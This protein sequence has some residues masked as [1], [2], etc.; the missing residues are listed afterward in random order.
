MT[1]KAILTPCLVMAMALAA[2]AAQD[3]SPGAADDTPAAAGPGA[4][5]TLAPGLELSTPCAAVAPSAATAAAMAAA[6]GSRVEVEAERTEYS[7][8]YVEPSGSHTIVTAVAPQ[9]ARRLDGTWGPI[10]TTLVQIGDAIVP[11][12]SA[13]HLRFSTGGAG[14]FVTLVHDGHSFSLSWPAPLPAPTLAGDTATYANV[15]PDVDLVVRATDAGFSHL[16]VVKTA[17]AAAHPAVRRARYR[18]G[19]D[20]TLRSTPDGG[21][22]AEAGGVRVASAGPPMMWGNARPGSAHAM[23][24]SRAGTGAGRTARVQGAISSGQLILTPDAAMLADPG[25]GFPLVIDP[26]FTTGENQWAYASADN[27]NAPTTD[28][29][30]AAGDPSPAAAELRVGNDP[31]SSH[32][33]RSFMRFPISTVAGR[34]ILTAQISG[35]V[36]HTWKCGSNRPTYFYRTAGISTTPRQTWPGPALQLLLGNDNVHANEDSC[37]EA[38]MPFEVSTSTLINDLQASANAS[39]GSYFIGIS[40]GENTSGLNETDQ[41]RWM[42]YFLADFKLQITY[43]TKPNKPD[44]LTVDGKPCVSGA[45]RPFVK[46]TTPTLRAHVVDPDGDTM[47]VSFTW[48]KWNGTSFVDEPGGGKQSNVPSGGT[49]LFN[50]TGNVDGGIYTFR[51]QSDDSPSHSPHLVSDV[52]NLPGNCEWQVDISPPAVPTVV[53]DVYLEGPAGCPGG[54]CGSV[55]QTGHFTFSSSSDTQ[56][57][58]W[59][60]SDPP[61]TPLTPSA[62]G[63]SVSID[64]TPTSSG[65]RTLFVRAIDRAGNVADKSYQFIVAAESTALAR[66]RLDDT[67]GS[68][69]TGNGFAATLSGGPVLGAGRIVPGLDGQSRSAL[70]FDGIDDVATTAGPVLADTSKSFSVAAW[71][72]L[73]DNTAGHHILEQTGPT[74]SALLLEYAHIANAWKITAPSADG[75]AFPGAASTSVPRLNTWTHVVGTYDSAAHTMKIYVNGVPETTA[76]GITTWQATGPLRIGSGW[77]GSLAEVQVWNRVLSDTEVFD[78]SDPMKVGEVAV[79]HMEEVGPGPAF[80][81]SALAHDLT[82]FNGASIPPTGAGQT[83]TGLQLDGIDDYAAPDGQVLHTDQSFTVSLWVRPNATATQQ[84]FISQESLSPGT[85]GGFALKFGPD[86]GGQWKFRIYASATDSADADATF[87]TAPATNVTTAF[88]HLVGVFDA[89]KL[90]IRLYVDGALKMTTAMN[91]QWHA[92]DAAGRLVLGRHQPTSTL[93]PTSGDLDEVRVYQGVVTDVTRIP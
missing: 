81:S 75:T 63:G 74:G 48:A 23:A 83:G 8:V 60:W 30:I 73:S 72:K 13:A 1:M 38:N 18:V 21:L 90:E 37:G 22:V 76:T 93:E 9:R 39:A 36:D 10:D 7:E 19:G 2:C 4:G 66:W 92:W 52:T 31:S 34:Q 25:A 64:W 68:D 28:S 20:A 55:G 59:G 67:T 65:P 57:F 50:V 91:A 49:A 71:V 14:P 78:L 58:L 54:A 84:T 32:L 61:T 56:S 53:S 62:L 46:T 5:V 70:T 42:R 12:A 80:D 47:N 35:R 29:T 51:A 86:S 24:L 87:A 77:A 85:V 26:L 89:Q 6:C 33:I 41:E 27:Q 88:H 79:W 17:R 3:G 40:A 82:F 11:A 15:L 16:L 69:D 44:S 45:N 43:N